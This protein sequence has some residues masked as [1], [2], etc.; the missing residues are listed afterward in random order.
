[1][2]LAIEE[3]REKSKKKVNFEKKH[4]KLNRRERKA[5][6]KDGG[7]KEEEKDAIEESA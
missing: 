3:K 2:R 5:M 1:M 4:G 6:D 7:D